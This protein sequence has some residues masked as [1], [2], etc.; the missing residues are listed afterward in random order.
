MT[1]TIVLPWYDNQSPSGGIL[2]IYG[3]AERLASKGHLVN[4]IYDCNKGK[5]KLKIPNILQCNKRMKN[6][7]SKTKLYLK[8]N[9]RETPVYNVSNSTIPDAD[10]VV[11][12]ALVTVA[13]VNKLSTEKGKKVY[14]IQGFENWGKSDEEVYKTYGLGML[15]VTV[16][17]W[18]YDIVSVHSL[19]PTYYIP[20]AV[21]D[22][23]FCDKDIETRKPSIG[24][25]YVPIKSKG[26]YDVLKVIQNIHD[27]KP[28]I[29]IEAFG[30]Y[31][32]NSDLPPYVHYTFSP[33]RENLKNLYNR[34]SIF[35]CASWLEGFGLTAAESMKCGCC[36]VTTDCKGVRDF[37]IDGKT[38]LICKP[39]DA[40]DMLNKTLSVL[41]ND[42]LRID[43]A[44][45][46]LKV[47]M[48]FNWND[49][50]DKLERILLENK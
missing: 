11:A 34:C 18:L 48:K 38:A 43:V 39:R 32:R 27:I 19:S 26:T 22:S 30:V 25:M 37:S 24:F 10:F 1:I 33:S 49:N 8:Q 23:I 36:L 4:I 12:T 21:D 29:K 17:K 41:N 9:I 15:N 13:S 45:E 2:N 5:G 14:F 3:Y 7:I 16:S 50:I 40:N 31:P 44:K 42:T 6:T 28:E 47:I 35:I 46:G 20:N